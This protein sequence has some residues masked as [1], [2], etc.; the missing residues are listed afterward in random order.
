MP[1]AFSLMPF[2]KNNKPKEKILS[3]EAGLEKAANFCAY[4]ERSKAE[5]NEKLLRLGLGEADRK[6][7]IGQLEA[8]NYLDET[9]FTRSY[10]RGKL[11]F[12]QWGKRKI[13]LGLRQ[14]GIAPE[15]GQKI[16]D[17]EVSEEQYHEVFDGLVGKKSA[18]LEGLP[19][20]EKNNKLMRFAYSHGFE[21]GLIFSRLG[22]ADTELGPEP[23]PD[24][25]DD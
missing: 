15:M 25:G 2:K 11:L 16:W 19:P 7:I 12:Q 4:Q 24:P 5:V 17:E 23:E 1:Q 20:V 13:M 8:D 21:P 22:Q 3:R 10:I 9:R 6:W 14:K 18:Q